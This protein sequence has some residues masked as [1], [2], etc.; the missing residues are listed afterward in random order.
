MQKK[1]NIKFQAIDLLI[2]IICIAGS[3]ASGMAFWQEYNRTLIK[4]NEDPVGTIVFKKRTAERKFIDRVVWDRLRDTAPVYNGDTIR[5]IEL[6]EAILSFKDD[7]THLTLG[8]NTLI[9][10][11]F[12]DADGARIDFTSGR[13]EVASSRSVTVTTGVSEV[14]VEGQVNFDKSS[15]GFSLSV[16][17]G[18]AVFDGEIIETGEILAIDSG[19]H[20]DFKPAIAMTSFGYSARIMG[21]A[22]QTVPVRFSWNSSNFTPDTYVIIEVALDGDFSN[23]VRTTESSGSSAVIQMDGG[24]YWW[25]AYPA[26]RGSRESASLMYPAG[27]LEIITPSPVALVSP[28][29]ASELTTGGGGV[30]FSWTAAEGASSYNLEIS[31]NPNMSNP[32]ISRIAEGTNIVIGDLGANSWYWRVTPLLPSWVTGTLSPSSVENFT[33]VRERPILSPPELIYPSANEKINIDVSGQSLIWAM[34]YG[35]SSWIVEVADNASFIN[36][37]VRRTITSNYFPLP[38]NILQDERTWYW[39]ITAQGGAVPSVSEPRSFEVPARLLA[40]PGQESELAI[41][42]Q[43]EQERMEQERLEQQRQEQIRLEQEQLEQERLELER[44]EQERLELERLEQ[45]RQEQIRQEQERL[46]LLRQEQLRQEQLRQ[47]Q[48]RQEQLRQ[49]QLRQE[50]LRI[51]QERLEQERQE[52]LRQER[53]RQE[54][55]RQEQLRIEQEQLRQEQ[56]RQEQLRQEQLR[57]EQERLEQE[58]QEQLRQERQRQEQLRQEQL[59][60]E[61]EQQRQEQQRQEEQQLEQERQGQLRQEEQRREELQREQERQE[62]QRQEQLRQE[63]LRTEQEQQRQE[64]QRL[65]QERLRQEAERPLTEEEIITR[66]TT[67]SPYRTVYNVFPTDGYELIPD[68]I[69]NTSSVDFT[70]RST[71]VEQRFALYRT[72]GEVIVPPTF[73][74]GGRYS[75]HNPDILTEGNYIWQ[76]YERDVNGE[77][78]RL[79]SVAH[80]FT[81]AGNEAGRSIRVL[82]STNPG[83]LYGN[84]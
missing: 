35:V 19:G 72:T 45:E 43:Q 29:R 38:E 74:T 28:A 56:L 68:Q 33:I 36:P 24:N 67:T 64:E 23:V 83:E 82:P 10:I 63:Q 12:S 14:I 80:R 40:V 71:A 57:I 81:V 11:F 50:Q 79:P 32:V 27:T 70:W 54:Q 41:A 46:E 25:R 77:W 18:E 65:E 52:Q 58:R 8:E 59:R 61:Q 69:E 51:E 73:V 37:A 5:T 44:L 6:S 9:Q 48:L 78:L 13:M 4:L 26:I 22:G 47:E 3:V 42:R 30:N 49:E 55:L 39:Q 15:E 7:I 1:R 34:D 2:V 21:Q 75:I 60:I 31:A 66:L 20:R 17:E 76:I 53:Q 62:R 16:L 84:R